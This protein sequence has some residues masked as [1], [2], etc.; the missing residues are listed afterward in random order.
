VYEA[1]S[2]YC[3]ALSYYLSVSEEADAV[4][5]EHRHDDKV[6]QQHQRWPQ[7]ARKQQS[8]S[9]RPPVYALLIVLLERPVLSAVPRK[10]KA[11]RENVVPLSL[12]LSL[13]LS[14]C[15]SFFVS[16]LSLSRRSCC[17]RASLSLSLSQERERDLVKK[18]LPVSREG[19]REGGRERERKRERERERERGREG[20]RERER[21]SERERE[22]ARERERERETCCK[23]GCLRHSLGPRR[24]L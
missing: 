4:V 6:D 3:K 15:L 24:D 7:N 23:R 8:H 14:L 12:S 5:N 2:D 9:V 13:S 19:G 16:P 18:G 20:E 10:K 21:A 17:K 1:L 22:R 11:V